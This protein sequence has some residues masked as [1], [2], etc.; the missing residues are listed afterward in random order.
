MTYIYSN[1]ANASSLPANDS[2]AQCV[3]YRNADGY[4]WRVA[5]SFTPVTG[6]IITGVDFALRQ[7]LGGTGDQM[8]VRIETN[9]GGKPS[10]TLVDANLTATLAGSS[11]SSWGWRGVT[12]TPTRIASGVLMWVVIKYTSETGTNVGPYADTGTFSNG[13]AGNDALYDSNSGVWTAYSGDL[14]YRISGSSATYLSINFY[15]D[16]SLKAYYPCEG[17]SNDLKDSH[18]GTDVNATYGI[19]YGKFSQGVNFSAKGDIVITSG[20]DFTPSSNFSLGCWF[21]T[22]SSTEQYIFVN[23]YRDAG[24]QQAGWKL[25]INFTAGKG[26]FVIGTSSATDG[27]LHENAN[28]KLLESSESTWNNGAWHLAVATYDGTT[29]KIYFDGN[30]PTSYS[31]TLTVGYH[32]STVVRIGADTYQ[33]NPNNIINAFNGSIDEVFFFNGK[34]LTSAEILTLFQDTSGA[35][36]YNFI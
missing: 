15:T 31:K 9:S 23:H 27:D 16:S 3:G 29:M 25:G 35:F 13:S 7:D 36:L 5:Q 21:K 33:P 11:A 34:V 18:N 20:A 19:S 8:T 2:Y 1:P 10:G 17:N 14:A 28:I 22:S 30:N 4:Y 26:C 32:G 12:F 6:D 24:G